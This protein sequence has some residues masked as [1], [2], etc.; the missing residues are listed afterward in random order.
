VKRAVLCAALCLCGCALLGKNAPQVPRY[1]MADYDGDAPA[2]PVHTGL[3]LRLG[4]VE[5]WAHLRERLAGRHSARELYFYE[6]RR[7][8]E[9][10]ETFLRRALERSLFEER[11]L[12]QAQSA[13]GLTLDVELMA[14]EEIDQPHEARLQALL[15]LHDGSTSLLRETI[16]AEQPIAGGA[17]PAQAAVDALTLA[18]KDAVRHLSDDVVAALKVRAQGTGTP[19]RWR[20][21]VAPPQDPSVGPASA[22]APEPLT[23]RSVTFGA[24]GVG[25]RTSERQ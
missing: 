19:V 3:Q 8:S 17:D 15:V 7:W 4:R 22:P 20:P 11:G 1:F 2:A 6:D 16:T 10:P 9:L 13:G 25:A 23:E 21:P 14:F 24:A 18:L 5:G 12:V